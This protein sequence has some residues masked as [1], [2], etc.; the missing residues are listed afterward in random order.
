MKAPSFGCA[1]DTNGMGLER[2]ATYQ[3]FA[4]TE[5]MSL[6]VNTCNGNLVVQYSEF[7]MPSRGLPLT[8]FHTY[9]THSGV[10]THSLGIYLAF[11]ET[12]SAIW[13]DADGSEVLYLYNNGSFSPPAGTFD[14]LVQNVD[15]SYTLTHTDQSTHQFDSSGL[16]TQV[17]DRHGNVI[18]LSYTNGL[19]SQAQAAGGQTLTFNYTNSSLSSVSD[20]AGHT[21]QL[22]YTGSSL[23]S[24]ADPLTYATVL[25]YNTNLVT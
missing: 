13:H 6:F 20:A 19:L 7:S 17:R 21:V 3:S 14:H 15:L 11:D 12:G 18:G 22:G 25:S 24:F 9:N 5:R 4:L 2:Y 16:L 1:P 23:T 8:L 10:W